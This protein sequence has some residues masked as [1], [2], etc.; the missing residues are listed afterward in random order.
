[1]TTANE[2]RSAITT[3]HSGKIG[4]T[5][6]GDRDTDMI[7][8]SWFYYTSTDNCKKHTRDA[9]ARAMRKDGW[10]VK[11]ETNS[12]GWHFRAIRVKPRLV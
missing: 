11:T 3:K 4:G 10:D 6:N 5:I 9:V 12:L 8:A 1:M 7:D 2:W